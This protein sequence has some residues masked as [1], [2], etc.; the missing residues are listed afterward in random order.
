M[1]KNYYLPDA[2]LLLL[3]VL[4][5]RQKKSGTGKYMLHI[6]NF[7]KIEPGIYIIG[8]SE[9]TVEWLTEMIIDPSMKKEYFSNSSPVNHIPLKEVYVSK[10]LVSC[11]EFAD[12]VSETAY[13]TEAEKDGWGWIWKNQWNKKEGVSWKTPFLDEGD[14]IYK[15][16]CSLFPALQLS[17]N[18]AVAYCEWASKK[19]NHIIRLPYEAEWEVFAGSA[20]EGSMNEINDFTIVQPENSV[21]YLDRMLEI[22]K[23]AKVASTGLVWEWTMDWF[24]KYNHGK[25]NKEFGTVYKVQR[26]GSLMSSSIQKTREYR[27]RRCPTARSPY[28]GF[29]YALI[30]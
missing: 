19:N 30:P 17:W 28:Y 2:V 24:D 5:Y 18:D 9:E 21:D 8:I 13:V 6:D 10:K 15:D 27:F 11:C 12:F 4:E 29:R 23:N 3:A 7:I 25:D 20:G 1:I 26:G 16:N 14:K 22:I